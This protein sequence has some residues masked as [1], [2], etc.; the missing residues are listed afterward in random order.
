[1]KKAISFIQTA[2][3]DHSSPLPLYF[4]LEQILL[5]Q[6][7]NGEIT[8]SDP[9]PSEKEL[10]EKYGVSRITVRRA[11]SDLTTKGYLSRQSGRRTLITHPKIQTITAKLGGI[12]DELSKQGFRVHSRVFEMDRRSPPRKAARILGI[13]ETSTVFYFKRLVYV[14][15][16]PIALNYFYLNV[17][18]DIT[19]TREELE[20]GSVFVPLEHRYGIVLRR[21][22]QTIEATMPL[23][24]ECQLLG[25]GANVPVL[26]VESISC[27]GQDRPAS[28]GKIVY[29]GDR[30]K[31]YIE[32]IR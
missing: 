32:A 5:R 17:V 28:Y 18:P 22:K 24:E 6:I 11:L 23:E 15:G 20:R 29:R 9:F 2:P 26:L 25:I 30:Y 3:I 19:F 10:Q 7:E 21:A 4:Q 1:M 16:E 14:D 8:T 31:H 27:D 13:P 12:F